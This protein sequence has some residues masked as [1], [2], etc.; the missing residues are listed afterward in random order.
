MVSFASGVDVRNWINLL[1]FSI[2]VSGYNTWYIYLCL[3]ELLLLLMCLLL[4]SRGRR[5]GKRRKINLGVQRV[6][7]CV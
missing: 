7:F 5:A 1:N 2:I 6:Q 3:V 4:T